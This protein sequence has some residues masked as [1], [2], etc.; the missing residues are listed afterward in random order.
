M[1]LDLAGFRTQESCNLG[2]ISTDVGGRQLDKGGSTMSQSRCPVNAYA[3][4]DPARPGPE[5][6]AEGSVDTLT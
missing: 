2:C 1:G 3:D 4:S 5:G 6:S